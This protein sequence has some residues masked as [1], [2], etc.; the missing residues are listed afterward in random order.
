MAILEDFV[1]SLLWV[2]PEMPR[3]VLVMAILTAV[4]VGYIFLSRSLTRLSKRLELDPHITNSMRL[5]LRVLALFVS[6]TAVFTIYE[7]PTTWFVGGSALVGAIVG[8]GSSQT[9]NNI[10]AGFYVIL[11]RPFRVKD[12]VRI[13]DVEGQ[14][15]EI[16]INYTK[17][18]TP[19]FNL[20]LIPNTQVMNS[21]ILN[22]THE[23]LIKY[24]FT[25]TF[26]H[27]PPLTVDEI[28]RRC[29]EP[30]I[31]EFHEK[32]KD[33]VLRR[34]ECYFQESGS[35]GRSFRIRIFVPRGEARTL[36]SLQPELA[37]MILNRWDL[38]R[39]RKAQ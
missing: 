2:H 28:S 37:G 10:A 36:F 25:I 16:T 11:S 23:G 34:A 30:A 39:A 7:L 5:I 1:R 26:P 31:E 17:I 35:F 3:L 24:T 13:G 22:L 20:L 14:V 21:R 27:T 33:R 9:I 12:Y 32:Y 19:T 29:I 38:E 6:I 18:Y 4:C 15:E 8:F